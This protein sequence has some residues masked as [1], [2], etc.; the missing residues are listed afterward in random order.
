MRPESFSANDITALLRRKTIATM[1][2]LMA[3]VGTSVERT[4]FRKL[5][6][7]H[8]RA[9]YSHAG[10]Y[11]TLDELATFDPLGLWAYRA[12]WFSA[13]GSLVQTAAALVDGSAGGYR[14]DE[15]DAVL[16]VQTKDCLR[17]LVGR[18]RLARE[19][20][21][22]RYLYCSQDSGK[23]RAQLAARTARSHA[24][25]GTS[26][27]GA[28]PEEMKATIILFLGL[29]DERQRRVFAGLESLKLGRGGDILVAQMLGLDPATVAKG[30]RELIENK[31][32]SGRVRQVGGGRKALE[33]KRRRSSTA[34]PSS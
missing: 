2:E 21:A 32:E 1:P 11:Y 26:G 10:R 25:A 18:G 22:G 7:L 27:P 5:S 9:S 4:V 17:Q 19:E 34:S 13:H 23:R 29:L 6:G 3:A 12:V 31:L 30:R 20:F 15:L 33:K 8:Y 24:P 28:P 16:H 14:I